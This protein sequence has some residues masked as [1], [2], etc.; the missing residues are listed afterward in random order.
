M[1]PSENNKLVKVKGIIEGMTIECINR[2][3]DTLKSVSAD[4]SER[5]THAEFCPEKFT[6]TEMLAYENYLLSLNSE[7]TDVKTKLLLPEEWRLNYN[8]NN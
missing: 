1:K 3:L 5:M 7:L 4:I 8:A 2:Q 6:V